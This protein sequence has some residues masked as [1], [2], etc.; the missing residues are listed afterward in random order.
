MVEANEPL[1]FGNR[2]MAYKIAICLSMKSYASLYN[3]FV[4]LSEHSLSLDANPILSVLELETVHTCE[5][6]EKKQY[7]FCMKK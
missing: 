3:G 2:R 1:I 6:C 7:F 4:H 5:V